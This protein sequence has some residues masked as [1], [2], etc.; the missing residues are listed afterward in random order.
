MEQIDFH[1]LCEQVLLEEAVHTL[2]SQISN[3][4]LT[5]MKDY[6]RES[7]K[8]G[9]DKRFVVA[10]IKDEL[11][12]LRNELH[13]GVLRELSYLPVKSNIKLDTVED[14][15]NFIYNKAVRYDGLRYLLSRFIGIKK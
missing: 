10:A 1:C 8:P 5:A 9:A 6:E 4:A 13:Q 12:D 15:D 7:A 3:D 2:L 11:K 14:V